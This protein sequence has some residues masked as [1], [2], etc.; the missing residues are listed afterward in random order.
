MNAQTDSLAYLTHI[1][2]KDSYKHNTCNLYVGVAGVA[3]YSAASQWKAL[4]RPSLP[5]RQHYKPLREQET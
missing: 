5:E 1:A 2:F 3:S 4:Q